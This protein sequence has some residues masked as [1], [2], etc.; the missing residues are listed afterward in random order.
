[1][2]ISALL[3]YLATRGKT[4]MDAKTAHD[5]RIDQRM[6]AELERVYARMDEQDK[7]IAEARKEA[8]AAKA[9]A[10][11]R[12]RQ[13]SALRRIL[14]QIAE[15]WPD[16]HGPDLD[17]G[18]IAKVEDTTYADPGVVPIIVTLP[19]SALPITPGSTSLTIQ[20]ISGPGQ[21]FSSS[22]P[23]QWSAAQDTEILNVSY[24]GQAPSLTNEFTFSISSYSRWE[25]VLAYPGGS[26]TQYLEVIIP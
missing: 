3:V 19:A 17:P 11:E 9:T 25:V 26:I 14:H 18:D 16:S 8:E 21:F 22:L 7:A 2:L 4:R 1:M 20:R 15:Q 5:A 23:N 6:A 24:A 10:S 13:I 12:V